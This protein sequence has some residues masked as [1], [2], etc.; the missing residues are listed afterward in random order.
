[1]NLLFNRY[2]D[3][4]IAEKRYLEQSVY[5][6]GNIDIFKLQGLFL[7]GLCKERFFHVPL[8]KI[9]GMIILLSE[10]WQVRLMECTNAG[11]LNILGL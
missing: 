5:F 2:H 9:C 8:D 4:I 1:M 6:Y 10:S 3:P 11:R 7:Y